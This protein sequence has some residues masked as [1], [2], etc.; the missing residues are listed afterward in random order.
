M[1]TASFLFILATTANAF[2]VDRRQWF[3]QAAGAAAVLV[4]GA[5][6]AQAALK[7]GAASPFTGDYD[8]PNH[9]GCLRQVKVVGAPLRADGIRPKYPV[10]EVTGYDGKG[11]AAM[12]SDRPTRD[13]LWKI[14]G[15]LLSD[16]EAII[17]F[18]PKGGPA[19]LKAKYDGGIIFP[20]GNKWTK[21]PFGTN[22]RR[23]EDMSTLK[24]N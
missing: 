24:S 8:D 19:S 16:S 14:Q 7:T 3:G 5:Q 1:K 10:M 12:C 22:D 21:V 20:D 4:A 6:D 9:P 11:E 23:P 15:K 2:S 17:D 18:S 13:D